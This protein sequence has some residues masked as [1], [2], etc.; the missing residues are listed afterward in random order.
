MSFVETG[1]VSATE[2]GQVSAA[3]TRCVV[4]E[5][6]MLSIEADA[7]THF[8]ANMCQASVKPKAF[9]RISEA[10]AMP[11]SFTLYLVP[12]AQGRWSGSFGDILMCF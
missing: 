10:L 1:Q 7:W 12:A 2:T 3:D 6:S 11:K 5:T 4:K 9:M 8:R